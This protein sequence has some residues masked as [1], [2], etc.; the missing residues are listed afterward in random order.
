M[1]RF[2]RKN[3]ISSD[4]LFE[5]IPIFD[6]NDISST[7]Y[8]D[9]DKSYFPLTKFVLDD[10]IFN[11]EG[12]FSYIFKSVRKYEYLSRRKVLFLNFIKFY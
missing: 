11:F 10:E 5:Y 9:V 1:S 7:D 8:S 6:N 2:I 3:E 4:I 12:N